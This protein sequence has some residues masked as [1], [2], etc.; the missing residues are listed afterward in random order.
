MS[1]YL[2]VYPAEKAGYTERYREGVLRQ[3]LAIYDTKW[4]GHHEGKR[5]IFRRKDYMK[6]EQKRSKESKR[7]KWAKKGGCVAPFFV[8]AMPGSKLLKMMK[9]GKSQGN[10][11]GRNQIQSD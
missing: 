10:K 9:E 5:P 11:E 3:A 7:H 8:P 1:L 6:E 2:S 4:K